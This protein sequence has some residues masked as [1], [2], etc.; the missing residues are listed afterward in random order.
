[1]AAQVNATNLAFVVRLRTI[2]KKRKYIDRAEARIESDMMTF[3]VTEYDSPTP[4][5]KSTSPE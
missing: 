2:S 3:C 1:M 4:R 5:K